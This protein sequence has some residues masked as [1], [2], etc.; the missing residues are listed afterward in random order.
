MNAIVTYRRP[1]LLGNSVFNNFFE[2]FFEDFPS[3]LKQSTHGYPIADIYTS[4][5][6]GTVMEF[7]LAGFT[8]DELSVDVKPD[9]R[10]I[11]VSA[12]PHDPGEDDENNQRRIARR[13]FE[14]V[15]VNYDDNLDLSHATASYVN[16]LLTIKV[17]QRPEVQPLAIDIG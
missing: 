13:S 11:T 1:G 7:A 16:G 3:H 2:N 9:K 17:P 6:G 5:D 4:V 10:S 15:Y 14:K 8:R 12:K